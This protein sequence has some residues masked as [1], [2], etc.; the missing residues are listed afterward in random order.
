MNT[1]ILPCK[2]ERHKRFDSVPPIKGNKPLNKE[3]MT[4]LQNSPNDFL[5]SIESVGVC[6]V[7]HPLL[8]QSD[9]KPNTQTTVGTLSLTTGLSSNE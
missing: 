2:Q 5:F 9:Y 3:E 1:K 7:K 8:I 4:D 6:N